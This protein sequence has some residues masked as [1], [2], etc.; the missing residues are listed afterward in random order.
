[1]FPILRI[2]FSILFVDVL[3]DGFCSGFT[4]DKILRTFN[5]IALSHESKRKQ[6]IG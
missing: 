1:M 2:I 6:E 4:I 5:S 3:F